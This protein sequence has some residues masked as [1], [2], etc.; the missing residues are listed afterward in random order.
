MKGKEIVLDER[1]EKKLPDKESCYRLLERARWPADFPKCIYCNSYNITLR[2]SDLR[3]RCNNCDVVFSLLTSTFLH[4]THIS[5]QKWFNV[6][7]LML[8]NKK[9]IRGSSLAK[10]IQVNRNT[11][12]S[13]I[14]RVGRSKTRNDPFLQNLYNEL[15]KLVV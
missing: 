14:Y 6:V 13:M 2:Q 12:N 15:E 10:I 5:L 9:P 1:I 3:Y 4:G 8:I 7:F 11:A